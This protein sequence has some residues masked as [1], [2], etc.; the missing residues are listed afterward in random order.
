MIDIPLASLRCPQRLCTDDPKRLTRSRRRSLGQDPNT[1]RDL[2]VDVVGYSRFTG[3]EEDRILAR[4]RSLRSNLI[5][6]TITVHH[7][8]TLLQQPE[9][10]NY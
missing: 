4:Q 3:G 10:C 1:G 7:G 5:D 9:I 2:S 6:P 8:P